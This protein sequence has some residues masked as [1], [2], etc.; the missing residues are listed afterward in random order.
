MTFIKQNYADC[1]WKIIANNVLPE[2]VKLLKPGGFILLP[3]K[4]LV[5]EALVAKNVNGKTKIRE[6]LEKGIYVKKV[7]A[8]QNLLHV[9][10]KDCVDK[11][12]MVAGTTLDY[13]H[14]ENDCYD[15][16]NPFFKIGI[17]PEFWSDEDRIAAATTNDTSTAIT[18]TTTMNVVVNEVAVDTEFVKRVGDYNDDEDSKTSR[19]DVTINTITTI[20][21]MVDPDKN[22]KETII[23]RIDQFSM[24]QMAQLI[25]IMEKMDM[26]DDCAANPNKRVK[27]V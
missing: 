11:Q 10:T 8:D 23:S 7:S 19:D 13:G 24:A 9:A 21:T 5:Y 14:T 20:H 2:M 1:F 27:T 3:A 12:S 26:A 22:L 16:S 6:L 25:E 4:R 18:T 17:V 15:P